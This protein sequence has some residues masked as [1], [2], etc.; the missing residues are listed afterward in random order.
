[1]KQNEMVA[2]FRTD[3]EVPLSIGIKPVFQQSDFWRSILISVAYLAKFIISSIIE[4][5]T[6]I[7]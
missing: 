3:A 2:E 5:R 4:D 1:M 6:K 7:T